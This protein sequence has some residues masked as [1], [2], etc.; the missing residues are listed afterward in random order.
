MGYDNVGELQERSFA[1]M[2]EAKAWLKWAKERMS[3]DKLELSPGP[4]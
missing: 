3:R 1:G 2:V 4:T